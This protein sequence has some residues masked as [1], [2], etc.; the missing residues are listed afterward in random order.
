M[1]VNTDNVNEKSENCRKE[2]NIA[3]LILVQT[4]SVWSSCSNWIATPSTNIAPVVNWIATI[5]TCSA[6]QF[7]ATVNKTVSSSSSSSSWGGSPWLRKDDCPSWD[8]SPSYYDKKCWTPT[9][10]S[11]WSL[12]EKEENID[13]IYIKNKWELK[14]IKYKWVDIVSYEWYN[15]SEKSMSISMKIIDNKKLNL[16]DKKNYVNRVNEFLT[17][18][19]NL[20]NA[21]KEA[22][23]M[24]SKYNKQMALLI[25]SVEKLKND[26]KK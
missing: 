17:A 24:K 20:D 19:Y 13:S 16:E 7:I 14:N 9:I 22:K 6:S 15:L 11:T 21:D 4:D 12:N 10:I 8:F 3:Y 23:I 26:I 2:I 1:T 5:Y 25:W 18:K